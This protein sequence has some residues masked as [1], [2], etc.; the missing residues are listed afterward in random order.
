MRLSVLNLPFTISTES[1]SKLNLMIKG[2]NIVQKYKI[3]PVSKIIIDVCI[4]HS[5]WKSD[6]L[7]EAIKLP[8]YQITI[9]TPIG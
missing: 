7:N 6:N 9:I 3:I 8:V 2:L 5:D 1:F 4:V